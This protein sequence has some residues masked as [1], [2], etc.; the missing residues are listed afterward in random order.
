MLTAIPIEWGTKDPNHFDKTVTIPRLWRN[1]IKAEEDHS[2]ISN[3]VFELSLGRNDPTPKT[4]LFLLE[5]DALIDLRCALKRRAA[6]FMEAYV[7][8]KS[9]V[10]LNTYE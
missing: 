6:L 9:E 4:R 5:Y 3:I 1:A 2:Y 7:T 8:K 10:C